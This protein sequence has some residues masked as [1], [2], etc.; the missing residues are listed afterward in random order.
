[1]S[2]KS[3]SQFDS[4]RIFHSVS[5][6]FKLYATPTYNYILNDIAIDTSFPKFGKVLVREIQNLKAILLTHSH[7]D[8]CGNAGLLEKRF[9]CPIYVHSYALNRLSHP[10][11]SK[12]HP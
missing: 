11:L 8:H 2:M 1:M 12:I 7:M 4:V 6:F 5:T 10:Q 9:N 3:Y